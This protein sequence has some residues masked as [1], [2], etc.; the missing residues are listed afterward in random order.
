MNEKAK[1]SPAS[2][3]SFSISAK[4]GAAF[5]GI[6]LI[7]VLIIGLISFLL[8]KNVLSESAEER[9]DSIRVLVQQRL[10]NQFAEWEKDSRFL[11]STA[12]GAIQEIVTQLAKLS[13]TP[14]EPPT[15]Q[16]GI[17]LLSLRA[18][19]VE[20]G[21]QGVF[22]FSSEGKPISN[23]FAPGTPISDT[24]GQFAASALQKGSIVNGYAYR[25][26]ASPKNIIFLSALP[27]I[28]AETNI[29][30]G[31][32]VTEHAPNKLFNVLSFGGR[33][34]D[35]GLGKTG[36]AYLVGPKPDFYPMSPVR[37]IS[38]NTSIQTDG[39][40][41]AYSGSN[42]VSS[43]S[44]YRKAN[45]FGSHG[46]LKTDGLEWALIVEQ[47]RGEALAPAISVSVVIVGISSG[48]L[49]IV[50]V[51]GFAFAKVFSNPI[52][53]LEETMRRFASGDE[54]ARAEAH[55]HDEIGKLGLSFNN[56]VAE[57]NAAKDRIS[58]E[59]RR[60]QN[61]IQDFLLVVA[62]ASEGKLSVRAKKTEGVLGNVADA[63]NQMLYNV[64]ILIGEAKRVSA[65][66]E[67]AA[68]GIIESAQGLTQGASK[69]TD[70]VN[71]TIQDVQTFTEESQNVS[72]NSK[73]AATSASST[74]E[75]AET[76]ADSVRDAIAFMVRLQDGVQSTA[77]KIDTLGQ[78]SKE[79]SGIV[80][81]ISEISAETDVLAMNASI[82]AARAGEH[83]KGFTI[84]ADQVRA[85]ADRTRLATVEIE[86]LAR[87]IQKET[88]E[89][90]R[91]MENQ[92]REME[93]GVQQVSSAA[94]ALSN[95]VEAS[96]DSSTLAGQISQSASEQ[97]KR[98]ESVL[99]SIR[100]I[101]EIAEETQTKTLE[102]QKTSDR[103]A[104]LAVELNTQL[105]NFDID[106]DKAS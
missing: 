8:Y 47:D 11:G 100:A 63:L 32:L 30:V 34:A 105:D 101:N 66:V 83:G 41:K 53:A 15:F 91:Q 20:L 46:K 49:I 6:G 24:L 31:A 76:G 45:V 104:G 106:Q 3:F 38:G 29:K 9:I 1:T 14:G 35:A 25:G 87:G 85:L 65:E 18:N 54:S 13:Q 97:E 70:Q 90:V 48:W 81:S 93:S 77:R 10:D 7:S 72:E 51:S 68:G 5:I 86:K 28:D 58:T 12:K 67:R 64:G 69:Q 33:P 44:N 78:R 103:L 80:Q 19:A 57:R 60:L 2:G 43:Y 23:V 56:M 89:G 75:A 36:Q 27:I 98:A 95:I 42:G 62:D 39:V 16:E 88:E 71:T 52:V 84:V 59:N 50:I 26:E 79:I 22:L 17:Y 92:T 74:R 96:V 40:R 94:K 4:I 73:E 61:N 82:E 21:I 99:S 102:F 37:G 55:N